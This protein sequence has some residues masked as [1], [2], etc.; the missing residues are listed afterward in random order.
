MMFKIVNSDAVKCAFRVFHHQHSCMLH[1][2]YAF[3]PVS[4]VIGIIYCVHIHR[5]SYAREYIYV[6]FSTFVFALTIIL[7]IVVVLVTEIVRKVLL[8]YIFIFLTSH[9]T[10]LTKLTSIYKAV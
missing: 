10:F 6:L 4:C 9:L 3:S 2:V 7:E 5:Q 1:N 8:T